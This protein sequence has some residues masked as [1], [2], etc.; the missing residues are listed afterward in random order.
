MATVYVSG[1]VDRIFFDGR[2]VSVVEVSTIKG[3]V[4]KTYWTC[5][6]DEAP[7][8]Q[9]GDTVK[10]SGLFG[11]KIEDYTDKQGVDR[12][13][14]V[15]SLNKA[16]LETEKKTQPKPPPVTNTDWGSV[17]AESEDAPF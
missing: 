14:V 15:R 7:V 13:K 4:R 3:E 16:K 8:V 10:V 6:F 12:R 1:T 11:D 5:W 17:V 9:L 2:G